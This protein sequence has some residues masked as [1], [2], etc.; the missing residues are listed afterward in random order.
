MKAL[1]G[2]LL[3]KEALGSGEGIL[4]SESGKLE[5]ILYPQMLCR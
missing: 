4:R 5:A 3:F 1:E 2:G